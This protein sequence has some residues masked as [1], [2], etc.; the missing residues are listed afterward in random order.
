MSDQGSWKGDRGSGRLLL[1]LWLAAAVLSAA[2]YLI[3]SSRLAGIGF[4]LDDAWIHQ[5]YARNLGV[6]GEWAFIPGR[7]SAGSTAPLW[8][9]LL[10]LGYALG[11]DGRWWAYFLGWLC[12]SGVA[13]SGAYLFSRLAA[14]NRAWFT[15][16]GLFL[17]FEYHLA[18]SAVS[19][20]ET[21]FHAWLA[22]IVVGWTMTARR[23]WF[24]LGLLIGASIWVRPD[25]VTLLAP[26]LGAV[27][28][29]EDGWRNRLQGSAT[30][31]LGF[32]LPFVAY[33]GWNWQIGGEWWPNTFYAKQ[34]EYAAELAEPLWRRLAEQA[35]LPLIGAGALLLPG[36]LIYVYTSLRRREWKALLGPAWCLGW[37][38]LYAL[39]LPVSYQHGRYLIPMM[40][41][42]FLYGLLGAA[43]WAETDSPRLWRRVLSKAWAL[44]VLLTAAG[45]WV[46]GGR[47]Y[48]KD[49]A[50][51]ETEMTATA[52]WV[53]ANLPEEA[54]IAA[55]D[56]GALGF[57]A[58]RDLIDLAGLV[59]PEVIPF[60][61][62]EGQ[63]ADFLDGRGAEYLVTF[64]GWYPALTSCAQPI[65]TSGGR[66]SQAFDGE[67]MTVYRWES[68]CH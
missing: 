58:R 61:R 37:I 19:G 17:I 29:A 22:L 5:T 21:L 53:A 12:L 7:A 6:N 31:L 41:V 28:L 39:R 10:A 55:H 33:L 43:S 51:I 47:A 45:F 2:A 32:L 66:Y 35:G 60:I 56:I 3:W 4:P 20:M 11:V 68:S 16:V 62:D 42:F 8:T 65:F 1:A 59:S 30:L 25:G 36:L 64:P 23:G 48:A 18:W 24:W 57:Y 63:L 52:Q 46:L 50:F 14:R 13:A 9:A 44:A 67:N 49:V 40:P 15:G 27:V 38:A 34:A 54:L 26:V